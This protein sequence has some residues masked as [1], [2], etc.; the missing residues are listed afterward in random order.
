MYPLVDEKHIRL[1][2]MIR[3]LFSLGLIRDRDV[4]NETLWLLSQLPYKDE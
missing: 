4:Y 2:D 1:Y 3:L